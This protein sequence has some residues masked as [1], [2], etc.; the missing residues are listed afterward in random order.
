MES[1]STAIGH[2]LRS[3]GFKFFL[4]AGLILL[5][6]IPLLLVWVMVEE[7]SQHATSVSSQIAQEWGETQRINGP[8]LI[9]PYTVSRTILQGDKQ[10][11]EVQDRRAVFLP[12]ATTIDS[13]AAPKVLTRSIYNVTV[14]SSTLNFSGRFDMPKLADLA[15]EAKSIRWRDAVVAVSISDVSG[16]KSTAALKIDNGAEIAFDPSIGVPGFNSQGIHVR[17]ADT[18]ALNGEQIKAFDF[19]FALNLDGSSGMFFS[20][21]ARDTQISMQS[22]WPHPSFTGSFLPTDRKVG[23][24]GFTARWQIPHLARSVPQAWTMAANGEYGD[25]PDQR[26]APFSFGVNYY[27]PVDFYDLVSRAAKYAL[28]FLA[29]AFMAVFLMEVGGK[30]PVHAVQYLF[31]GLSMVFFYVLLLSLSE[32]I[33]FEAAYVTAAGAT[34]GM[35]A[36]YIAKAQASARKGLVMFGVLVTLYAL[37]YLILRLEDY[38]LLAGAIGGFLA[39]TAVMFATLKVDWSG[40]NS[41]A[42]APAAA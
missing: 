33:G 37:L 4:I 35:L 6:T 13:S 5:L 36:V 30:R 9:V 7:R 1:V 32:H 3:P 23:E 17:L 11:E 10:I 24:Q 29:T 26:L 12:S 2:A 25:G 18:P 27:I 34:S 38:A 39:L 31:V 41:Q 14:Y 16:L 22:P 40:R 8:F 19:S 20:P 21:V 42:I 28:M 15:P